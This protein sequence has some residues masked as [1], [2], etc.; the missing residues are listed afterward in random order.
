MNN[1]D[2]DDDDDAAVVRYESSKQAN[3]RKKEPHMPFVVM[4]V[5]EQRKWGGT[6]TQRKRNKV[7]NEWLER[8][9]SLD[10]IWAV[11]ELAVHFNGEWCGIYVCVFVHGQSMSL[12]NKNPNQPKERPNERKRRTITNF[13]LVMPLMC[14][15]FDFVFHFVFS[16][17]AWVLVCSKLML[18]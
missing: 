7:K 16:L 2:D 15:F 9:G 8:S 10:L 5:E 6:E 13:Y 17:H 1:T 12:N 11:S 3:E 4:F 18:V 14:C